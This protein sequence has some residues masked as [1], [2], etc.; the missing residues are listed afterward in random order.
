V[1]FD[2]EAPV[3]GRTRR[4]RCVLHPDEYHVEIE[5]GGVFAVARAGGAVARAD[6]EPATEDALAEALAAPALA[7]GC[8][9]R[10]AFCLHASGVERRGRAVAFLG[11]SG[12][13][14]S[15]LAAALAALPGGEWRRIADDL[16]PVAL[17]AAGPEAR[18]GFP[19]PRIAVA[20]DLPARLPLAAAYV[21][22]GTAAEV[23]VT[24]LAPRDAALALV[25]HTAASHLFAPD[26]LARHLEHSTAVAAAAAVRVLRYPW[27]AEAAAGVAAALA[28]DL[29]RRDG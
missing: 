28:A 24:P 9:L 20:S 6:G 10:G 7:L 26:L 27:T 16:L 11:A 5:G 23:A 12:A 29:E 19:Q 21:L 13:G 22:A 1:L 2:G 4:V 17:G 15:T 18:P 3:A 25:R 14:K 8:A